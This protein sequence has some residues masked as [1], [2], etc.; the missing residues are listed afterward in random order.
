M[1]V[2]VVIRPLDGVFWDGDAPIV[3]VFDSREKAE[4][5]IKADRAKGVWGHTVEELTVQ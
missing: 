3:G 5:A 2:F 4:A 1:N